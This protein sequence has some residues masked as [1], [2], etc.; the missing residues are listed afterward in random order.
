VIF[1]TYIIEIKFLKV[2]TFKHSHLGWFNTSSM[3]F[4]REAHAAVLLPN[5]KVL[6]TGGRTDDTSDLSSA[7]LYK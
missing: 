1:V 6:V 4:D 7:E 3:H 2:N 5:G